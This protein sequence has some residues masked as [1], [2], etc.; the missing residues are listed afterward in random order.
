MTNKEEYKEIC[1]KNGNGISIYAQH[2]WMDAVCVDKR[3]D[4]II[5]R[6]NNGNVK[7]SLPYLI[8]SK[9]GFRFIIMP[10]LT[11]T[12]G[13]HYYSEPENE[14]DRLEFE[15]KWGKA[16]IKQLEELKVSLYIQNFDSNI[17]NWLPFY[18]EGYKQTTRYTYQIP[19]ISDTDK[20]FAAFSSAKQRQIRKA[21][22]NGLTATVN[23][24][25]P[26]EFYQYHDNLIKDK[27]EKNEIS[28]SVLL[29]LADAAIS[30]GQGAILSIK[31]QQEEIQAAL[32]LV[33]DEECA[34]Y[35]VPANDRK[36]STT[37][38]S[39]LLV[40]E[41]IKYAS[42]FCRSFDFEGSM[43]ESIENSYNQFGTKQTTYSKITKSGNIVGKLWSFLH[44]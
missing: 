33:W 21:E 1:E 14:R 34:Y 30:R 8:G 29:S 2:W 19:D 5:V 6:D 13:I 27:G 36:Y 44:N 17:T 16:V 15:K 26:A 38:A 9:F 42:Q 28:E 41:A 25:T 43:T 37:G 11:Q 4:V 22:R 18:W 3:W 31:G 12:N 32:F 20:V 40:W 10:P 35:L 7:A 23:A 39:T 24:I